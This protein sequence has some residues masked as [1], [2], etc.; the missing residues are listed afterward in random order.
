MDDEKF[1]EILQGLDEL[2]GDDELKALV[3]SL[4]EKFNTL[5]GDAFVYFSLLKDLKGFLETDP[6][7]RNK[8]G[9]IT[10]ADFQEWKAR[11]LE[12]CSRADAEEAI[13]SLR[14]FANA[15][16][17]WPRVARDLLDKVA[18]ETGWSPRRI[19]EETGIP[20]AVIYRYIPRKHV[21][22]QRGNNVE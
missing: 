20:H 10:K 22:P 4:E 2:G 16:R 7:S 15:K 14:N 5:D 11:G 19:A 9:S 12:L 3:T 8:R 21:R 6:G 1:N 18:E 17:K 13:R